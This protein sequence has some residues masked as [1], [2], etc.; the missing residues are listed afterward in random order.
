MRNSFAKVSP[1]DMLF[2]QEK[3]VSVLSDFGIVMMV[4]NARPQMIAHLDEVK[5]FTKEI[6]P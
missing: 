6:P 2:K 1:I 4:V 5:G 3:I